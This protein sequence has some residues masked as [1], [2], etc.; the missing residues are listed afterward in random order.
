MSLMDVL[1]PPANPWLREILKP[2]ATM[3]PGVRVVR[4]SEEDDEGLGSMREDSLAKP[5]C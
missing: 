5:V 4:F 3:P 1:T 2:K